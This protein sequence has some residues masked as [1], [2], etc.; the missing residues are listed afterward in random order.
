M[1][2]IS[3]ILA[4]STHEPLE[5]VWSISLLIWRH[6]ERST[7]HTPV[8]DHVSCDVRRD[9]G[10]RCLRMSH[11]QTSDDAYRRQLETAQA[12]RLGYPLGTGTMLTVYVVRHGQTDQ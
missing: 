3:L 12:L 9:R 6:K 8:P 5:L 2:F 10:D 7:V 11:F 1:S 4:G